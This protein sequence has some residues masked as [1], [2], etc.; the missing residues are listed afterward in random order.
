MDAR[1]L[2]AIIL[3]PFIIVFFYAVFHELRRYKS[4]GRSQ[5]GLTFNEETG[6]SHVGALA[7]DQS[8]FDPDTYDPSEYNDPDLADSEQGVEEPTEDDDT[9]AADEDDDQTRRT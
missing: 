5:Y 3:S 8:A 1:L 6:T 2:A 7:E 4:E 9:T